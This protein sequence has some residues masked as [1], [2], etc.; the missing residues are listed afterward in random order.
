MIILE[1]ADCTEAKALY[2]SVWKGL[3]LKSYKPY[4]PQSPD[5][6]KRNLAALAEWDSSSMYAYVLLVTLIH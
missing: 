1:E 5:G 3:V 6:S 2:C 4:F